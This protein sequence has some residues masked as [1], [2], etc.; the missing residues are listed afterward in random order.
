[1]F[2]FDMFKNIDSYVVRVIKIFFMFVKS[3]INYLRCKIFKCLIFLN[4][5]LKIKL[6]YWKYFLK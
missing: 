1:M 2:N 5:I 4:E 6:F 3:W